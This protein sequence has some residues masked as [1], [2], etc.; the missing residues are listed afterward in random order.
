MAPSDSKKNTAQGPTA[1]EVDGLLSSA[2]TGDTPTGVKTPGGGPRAG[3][4]SG[5]G[6]KGGGSQGMTGTQKKTATVSHTDG[7]RGGGYVMQRNEGKPGRMTGSS[8]KPIMKADKEDADVEEDLLKR[9]RQGEWRV[10]ESFGFCVHAKT[11]V[12]VTG[13]AAADDESDSDDT[14]LSPLEEGEEIEKGCAI[15]FDFTEHT[16][17]AVAAD[18]GGL[19]A[20]MTVRDRWCAKNAQPHAVA[21]LQ[22]E[23]TATERALAAALD[24]AKARMEQVG[25]LKS[26]ILASNK[27]AQKNW[28]YGKELKKTVDDLRRQLRR[29]EDDLDEE[30]RRYDDSQSRKRV[31]TSHSN[32]TGD[33][34]GSRTAGWTATSVE[35]HGVSEDVTM[36]E[37]TTAPTGAVARS[38]TNMP[39]LSRRIAHDPA[40]TVEAHVYVHD[41]KFWGVGMVLFRTYVDARKNRDNKIDWTS[42]QS[43]ALGRFRMPPWMWK[44]L[45]ICIKDDATAKN[46][47]FWQ[48]VSHPEHNQSVRTAAAF[49]QQ[50]MAG[51]VGCPFLDDYNTLDARL[52]RGYLIWSAIGPPR[53]KAHTPTEMAHVIAVGRALLGVIMF[54]NTYEQLLAAEGITINT[55]IA[56]QTWNVLDNGV[57]TDIDTVRRLAAM[58]VTV[59]QVDNMYAFGRQYIADL[60]TH[61]KYGWEIEELSSML[62]NI[63]VYAATQNN[64]AGLPHTAPMQD[65]DRIPRVPMVPW[66]NSK[67]NAAQDRGAF[68]LNI[69]YGHISERGFTVV[70]LRPQTGT[71]TAPRTQGATS[72]GGAPGRGNGGA[73]GTA[74]PIAGVPRG[75]GRGRGTFGMPGHGGFGGP[76]YIGATPSASTNP[77]GDVGEASH[78]NS[79]T[80]AQTN[81]TS[82]SSL[83]GTGHPS[84]F[85]ATPHSFPT[86]TGAVHGWDGAPGFVDPAALHQPPFHS[87]TS[88]PQGTTH[89]PS[90]T[91]HAANPAS[92]YGLHQSMHTPPF[93]Q[94]HTAPP[95]H[96]TPSFVPSQPTS[97]PQ[98]SSGHGVYSFGSLETTST[99]H[100]FAHLHLQTPY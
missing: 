78:A 6:S 87:H 17:E 91:H 72:K 3:N 1:M 69:P 14:S 42:L 53:K 22:G 16:A 93:T 99:S 9:M 60:C 28:E 61:P 10:H 32:S 41:N 19:L 84:S 38:W 46:N 35:A 12:K 25:A 15:C 20:T 43:F 68:L 45:T 57:S 30:Q 67:I 31:A 66:E 55:T 50:R 97:Q 75:G 81:T 65:S 73:W 52:V 8:F 47:V 88:T 37:A 100:D 77:I 27:S 4:N 48:N 51:P 5:G 44:E 33:G 89:P 39:E 82:Q 86:A 94:S 64:G 70:T 58:G 49:L 80:F 7:M 21:R 85:T 24:D 95:S 18:D 13:D 62:A 79:G 23:L 74:R 71:P 90:F 96:S 92:P 40:M 2:V 26:D 98:P 59:E 29:T 11:M 54:P 76:S 34:R 36:A 83:F 63:D 56:F